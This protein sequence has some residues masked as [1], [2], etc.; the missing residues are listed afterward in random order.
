VRAYLRAFFDRH[1]HHGNGHLLDGPS[2]R[3][4]DIELLP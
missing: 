1:L 3:F 4:P 2:P